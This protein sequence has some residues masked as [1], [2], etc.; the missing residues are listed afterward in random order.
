VTYRRLSLP[1]DV[2]Q[3]VRR[4]IDA[5]AEPL[6]R[7]VH[8]MLRLPLA[9]SELRAGCG[10]S[11]VNV[12]LSVVSGA[13]V[14]LYSPQGGSG[15]LFRRFLADYYP[16]ASEPE[17]AGACVGEEAAE[18]LYDEFRNP[19]AH[20]LGISV[21][22]E[23]ATTRA[24]VPRSFVLKVKRVVVGDPAGV[25]T[26]LSETAIEEIEA[27]EQRPSWLPATLIKQPH[28]IVTS[29]EALYWGIRKAIEAICRD[30]S[31]MQAAEEFLKDA[32]IAPR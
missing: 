6:L 14:L 28:K 12:L 3:V 1:D 21:K 9:E 10:F 13:S 16:W 23:S 17:R 7:D 27:A 5:G 4:V 18:K 31:R 24:L 2:P 22:T 19:F 8:T 15:F 32:R 30:P 20:A 11:I 29:P 26:G 25:H